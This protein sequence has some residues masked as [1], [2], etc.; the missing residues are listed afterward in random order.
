MLT[1]V[2]YA[3]LAIVVARLTRQ[4]LSVWILSVFALT[5]L[6]YPDGI[7]YLGF[8]L[9]DY[10]FSGVW[11]YEDYYVWV[12]TMALTLLRTISFCH[13]Y[14][15]NESRVTGNYAKPNWKPGEYHGQAVYV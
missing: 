12:I 13:E 7:P 15:K 9:F 4:I 5:L 3:F 14:I 10:I 8:T 1:H 11:S 6:N 2:A